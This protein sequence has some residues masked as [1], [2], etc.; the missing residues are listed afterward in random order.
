MKPH[1]SD[2]ARLLHARDAIENLQPLLEQIIE[3]IDKV[4]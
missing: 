3:L 2:K 1:H 4:K